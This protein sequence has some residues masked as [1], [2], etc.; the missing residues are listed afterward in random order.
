MSADPS[1][2]HFVSTNRRV[3]EDRRFVAGHGN[4][5]ADI[6]PEGTLHVALLPSQYPSARILEI[7]SSAALAMPGVHYV[8]TGEELATAIDPLM[9][10]LDTPNARRYPLAVGQTRYAGEWVVAVVAE[11]RAQADANAVKFG[12]SKGDK[13]L[14]AARLEKQQRDLDGHALPKAPE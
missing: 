10:G 1:A 7:D 14:E 5:V 11:T 12:R 3:R 13:A 6:V 2:F 4:Y 9:N 8:L